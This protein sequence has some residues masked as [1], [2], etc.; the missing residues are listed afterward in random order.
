MFRVSSSLKTR[1]MIS[2]V[3]PLVSVAITISFL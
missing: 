2:C 3:A 1:P